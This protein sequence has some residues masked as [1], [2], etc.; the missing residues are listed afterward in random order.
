[1]DGFI[2]LAEAASCTGK[3]EMTIRRLAKKDAAKK[4]VSIKNGAILIRATFVES[5]YPFENKLVNNVIK[6]VSENDN[7]V[8][9]PN[10]DVENTLQQ[11][12]LVLSTKLEGKEDLL[13]SQQQYIDLLE[14][15]FKDYQE[16]KQREID[17]L[18]ERWSQE[19]EIF[20]RD[21]HLNAGKIIAQK[22]QELP[23]GGERKKRWWPW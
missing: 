5:I 2:S 16:E 23:E 11:E 17:R 3:S 12:I 21:Q 4:H 13:K 18:H 22:P 19:Q 1:M 10:V 8:N 9:K 6:N 14:K 15:R 7:T 20:K